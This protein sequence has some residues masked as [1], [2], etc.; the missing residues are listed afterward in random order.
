MKNKRI[1]K[2]RENISIY[3]VFFNDSFPVSSLISGLE[4]KGVFIA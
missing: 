1:R 3:A 4:E 2:E